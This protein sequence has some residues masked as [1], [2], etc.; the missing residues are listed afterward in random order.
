M[1]QRGLSG[2]TKAIKSIEAAKGIFRYIK[3]VSDSDYNTTKF[4]SYVDEVWDA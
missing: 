4:F 2:M 1:S 3:D